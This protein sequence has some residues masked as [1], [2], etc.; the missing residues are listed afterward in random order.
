MG[1]FDI[2]KESVNFYLMNI[3]IIVTAMLVEYGYSRTKKIL[4]VLFKPLEKVKVKHEHLEPEDFER[5]CKE[6]I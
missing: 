1:T 2:V 3:Y 6:Y 5:R 4:S